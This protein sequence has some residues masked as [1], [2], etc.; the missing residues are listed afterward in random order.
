MR[1]RL[2]PLLLLL[3]SPWLMAQT[4]DGDLVE[5]EGRANWSM[6]GFGTLGAVYH[7][8]ENTQFRRSIEQ[9]TGASDHALSLNTDSV[10]G[11]QLD[12]KLTHDW[13]VMAQGV[14]REG[15][16]GGWRPDLT[17]A[18]LKYVPNDAVVLRFGRLGM[19]IYQDGDSRHVGYAYTTVRPT[20]V[21]YGF[22]GFDTYDG[23]ELSYA[24]QL[25]NGDGVIKVYGGRAHGDVYLL[26]RY[27]LPP[28]TTLGV[29]YKWSTPEL[30]LSFAWAQ[31]K[32][33]TDNTFAALA[34][35][36]RTVGSLMGISQAM[37]RA[38]DIHNESKIAFLG[39]GADWSHGPYS[40]KG[41]LSAFSYDT[42]PGFNGKMAEFS[43]AYRTGKWKPFVAYSRSIVK[44]ND[45]PLSLPALP[46]LAN[47]AATYSQVVNRLADDE[48]SM[49]VGVRY[50]LT[51]NSAL[52]FQLDHIHAKRSFL[53][54]DDDGLPTQ[55][56]HVNLITMT[57]DFV[58]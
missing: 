22:L 25:G 41:V 37:A 34:S 47:L 44:A 23:A 40:I 31:I 9:K 21:I 13:S 16:D 42:F 6:S 1:Q 46:Q 30:A 57:Y 10:L 56:R 18:F 11:L 32:A 52:K 39:A 19:D 29:T 49:G 2:R 26:E 38:D 53:L 4:A 17:W 15:A 14:T 12:G 45:A 35:S 51:S 58:F 43:A 3:I 28:A 48:Y 20:P 27:D 8:A 24:H 50:D 7:A 36:L 54:L 33:P 5:A 55:N